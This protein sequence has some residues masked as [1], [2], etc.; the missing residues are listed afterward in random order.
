MPTESSRVISV[1]N[2]PGYT[3]GSTPQDQKAWWNENDCNNAVKAD[4]ANM[5]D[6]SMCPYSMP[7]SCPDTE[8]GI[9]SSELFFH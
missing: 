7:E 5:G 1:E 8:S 6:T 4:G 9:S 3:W 2:V